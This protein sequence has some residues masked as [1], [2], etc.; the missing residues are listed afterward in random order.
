MD[1]ETLGALKESI[2]KW[3]DIVG[4]EGVDR[5]GDN[6]ALCHLFYKKRCVGCP[7]YLKTG[8]PDCRN[9]PYVEWLIHQVE[10]HNIFI[11]EIFGYGMVCPVCKERAEAEL[12][13]LK[14][15]LPKEK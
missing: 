7:V 12:E 3:E 11:G 4:G 2:K 5:G 10:T 9:T 14:S 1:K 6:C 8:E 15:L 13:F